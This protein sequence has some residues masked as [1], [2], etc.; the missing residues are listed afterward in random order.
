MVQP[1]ALR[2]VQT[3]TMG[4]S[5]GSILYYG[6]LDYYSSTSSPVNSKSEQCETA[7]AGKTWS[8]RG[9]HGT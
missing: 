5:A 1:V 3:R 9:G 2:S 6:V 8:G 4:W 7:G